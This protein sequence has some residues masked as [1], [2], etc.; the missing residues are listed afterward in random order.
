MKTASMYV[1]FTQWSATSDLSSTSSLKQDNDFTWWWI[2]VETSQ[3][4][5][6]AIYDTIDDDICMIS[7]PNLKN[8]ILGVAAD[9]EVS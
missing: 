7:Y 6:K 4:Q 2:Y 1:Q 9:L 5:I 8:N 3:K